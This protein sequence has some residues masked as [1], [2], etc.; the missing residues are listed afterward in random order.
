M[1][2]HTAVFHSS[3]ALAG[4]LAAGG[5]AALGGVGLGGGGGLVHLL[6]RLVIWRELWRLA[7][8]LWR[9]PTFGP[10]IVLV[11]AAAL[12]ALAIFRARRGRG[13]A[14]PRWPGGPHGPG[15]GRTDPFGDRSGGRGSPRDW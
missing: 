1:A 8:Y 11:I 15:R 7:R 5:H 6:V 13:W 9:I 14:G 10:V 2:L 12:V 3:R 4:H